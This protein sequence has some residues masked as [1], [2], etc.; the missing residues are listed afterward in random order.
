MTMICVRVCV[1]VS[2]CVCAVGKAR[3]ERNMFWLTE[4][5][6]A[7]TF[8]EGAC[9]QRLA[10]PRARRLEQQTALL[11]AWQME[12]TANTPVYSVL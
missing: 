1:C 6:T 8:C 7:K 2:L 10:L 4:T 9:V 12:T 3:A 5:T 11:R